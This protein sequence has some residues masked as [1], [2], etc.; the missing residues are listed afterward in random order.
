[1]VD[2]SLLDRVGNVF[3]LAGKLGRAFHQEHQEQRRQIDPTGWN[4][5]A[6]TFSEFYDAMLDLRDAIQNPLD[7]FSPVAG[8][9]LEVARL[10]KGLRNAMQQPDGR[11]WAAY[12][13]FYPQLNSIL[14][15]AGERSRKLLRRNGW[16]IRSRSWTNILRPTS[17][18]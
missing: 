17:R 5:R 10:A 8:P 15:T 13:D 16:T 6:P 3:S 1:M 18:I 7:G 11:T 9:L 2:S 4:R 12:Q 14:K